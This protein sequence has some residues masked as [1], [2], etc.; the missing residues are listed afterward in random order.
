MTGTSLNRLRKKSERERKRQQ[1]KKDK[2]RQK[3]WKRIN[4]RIDF[5]LTLLVVLAFGA[6]AVW[7]GSAHKKSAE[8]KIS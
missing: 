4:S 5:L 6:A 7:E 2:L 3:R 1:R 8:R